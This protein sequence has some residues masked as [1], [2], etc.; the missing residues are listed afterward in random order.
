[1]AWWC[2]ANTMARCLGCCGSAMD[3]EEAPGHF[4]LVALGDVLA[5]AWCQS[6]IVDASHVF[7]TALE[8]RIPGLMD[9]G[10]DIL[11]SIS[12]A[13]TE[14]RAGHF[15]YWKFSLSCLWPFNSW[16]RSS[17]CLDQPMCWFTQ[18]SKFRAF[19]C[20]FDPVGMVL[21]NDGVF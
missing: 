5:P 12:C 6:F 4:H 18:P 2:S 19:S 14:T 20:G 7:D 3:M 13:E 9:L 16:S 15:H 11:W 10:I 1:M 21:C 17:L 8:V